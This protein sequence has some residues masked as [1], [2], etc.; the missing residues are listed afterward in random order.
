LH[1]SH[2]HGWRPLRL[3]C[4]GLIALAVILALASPARAAGPYFLEISE[5]LSGS[6]FGEVAC[7]YTEGGLAELEQPCK[8]EF[9]TKKLLKLIPVPEEGSEFIGFTKAEG[10]ASACKGLTK[11]CSFTLQADSYVEARFD[12]ITPALFVKYSGVGEGEVFC[13]IDGG[14]PEACEDEYEFRVEVTLVPEALP[15]SEFVGFKEGKGSAE[16]CVGLE[17]CS[18]ILEADSSIEAPFVPIMHAL[19]IAKTGSGSGTVTC[20]GAL[21]AP[22]YAEG[23]EVTLKAT[24]A[25]GSTFNG[26]SGEECSGTGSCVVKMEKD[27]AVIATFQASPAPPPP[28]PTEGTAKA[29]ATAKVKSGNARVKLICAG[30][31]CNGTLKLT[32]KVLQGAKRKSVT[33]GKSP[34]SV[35]DGAAK[36]VKVKLSTSAVRELAKARTLRA[37]AG[38]PD[39]LAGFVKLKLAAGG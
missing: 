21:C 20:N 27:A 17:P 3:G 16:E 12:E 9:E 6:G 29:A 2:G 31:P 15:G 18:F 11:P 24:P 22:I 8:E 30:G 5:D 37:R 1:W 39:V 10:S 23:S 34:F 7:E 25:S 14:G 36:T 35:A 13:S 32:A 28:P 19:T 33:I 38:G 26:W 4:A